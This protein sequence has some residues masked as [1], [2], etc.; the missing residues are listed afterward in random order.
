[1]H[2]E[3]VPLFNEIYEQYKDK[4]FNITM[5]YVQNP[6]DAEDITQDVFVEVH[7]SL[8]KFEGRSSLSTWIYR[9]AIN[10]SLDL[11][12]SRKR[13]KRFAFITS[14]F[15]EAVPGKNEL[16]DFHHPGIALENKENAALLFKEIQSLPENQKTAFLLSKVEGLKNS[17]ISEI[18]QLSVSSVESLLFRS[19][20]NLQK[21]LSHYFKNDRK[22]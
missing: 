10:R 16:S 9:I 6:E 17:E 7:R 1:M 13:K 18:M 3:Q 14:I 15:E 22:V 2:T 21:Q 5:G 12:K 20:Q 19:K 11:I 4:V 8:C